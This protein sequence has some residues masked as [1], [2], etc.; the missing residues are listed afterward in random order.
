[1]R[2]DIFVEVAKL[3]M[4]LIREIFWKFLAFREKMITDR[5][6]KDMAISGR[7]KGHSTKK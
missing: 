4:I 3:K 2:Y 5:P 7:T 6:G 1:M